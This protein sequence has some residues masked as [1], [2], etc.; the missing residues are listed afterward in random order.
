MHPLNVKPQ[1]PRIRFCFAFNVT[2]CHPESIEADFGRLN[3]LLKGFKAWVKD[4]F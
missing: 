1:Q 2:S 3:R 4:V